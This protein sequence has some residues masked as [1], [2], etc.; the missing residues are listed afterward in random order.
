MKKLVFILM[1]SAITMMAPAY[2]DAETL[3]PIEFTH[4]HCKINKPGLDRTRSYGFPDPSW[5]IQ[6]ADGKLSITWND[7][8]ANCCIDGFTRSI[9]LEGD[10][11]IFNLTEIGGYCSCICTYD[12]SSVF[13]GIAKGKYKLVFKQYSYI[14]AQTEVDLDEG[15][16]VSFEKP[17]SVNE[18]SSDNSSL[19]LDG[20]I[21]KA[22]SVGKFRLEVFNSAGSLEYSLDCEDYAELG[23]SGLSSGV[24]IVRLVSASGAPISLRIIR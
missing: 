9:E 12:V 23:L 14:V 17:L 15:Y 11:I 5:D 24:H 3:Y 10:T 18:V 16:E 7:F 19:M 4:S 21:V 1:L 8:E 13:E 20:E 22:S 6:Y 2:S